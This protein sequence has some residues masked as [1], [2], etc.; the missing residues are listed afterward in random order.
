MRTI[1]FNSEE[2]QMFVRILGDLQ[3]HQRTQYDQINTL[4][5][6]YAARQAAAEE[7]TKHMG[8]CNRLLALISLA[9][10]LVE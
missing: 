6:P 3:E 1:Q 8:A 10:E 2:R 7:L 4:N 9:K 5:L